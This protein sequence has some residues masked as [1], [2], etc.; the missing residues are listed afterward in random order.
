M[1]DGRIIER[2]THADLLAK[3]GV[4]AQMWTQQ[5]SEPETMSV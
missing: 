3:N 4:Y 5:Q 1:D 2:G